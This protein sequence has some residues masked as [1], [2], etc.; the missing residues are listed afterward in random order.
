MQARHGTHPG[1]VARAVE[2][3]LLSPHPKTRYLVGA[4]AMSAEHASSDGFP[5]TSRGHHPQ[6]RGSVRAQ[7]H[8]WQAGP[9]P[10]GRRG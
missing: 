7:R 1:K 2:H 6:D 10:L 9:M 3:A 5:T 4:D 8:L